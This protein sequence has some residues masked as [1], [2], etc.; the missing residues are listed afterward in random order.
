MSSEAREQGRGAF[1]PGFWAPD[2][3]GDGPERVVRPKY[4]ES[5]SLVGRQPRRPREGP[6]PCFATVAGRISSL[7]D[8]VVHSSSSWYY[9]PTVGGLDQVDRLG[10][11]HRFFLLIVSLILDTLTAIVPGLAS[12]T[13]AGRPASR[14]G[15]KRLGDA[16][17][18][19]VTLQVAPM[20][21]SRRGPQG[22]SS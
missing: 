15:S 7:G 13:P 10:G 20:G 3:L 6:C 5:R 12:S 17:G 2:F 19:G 11:R 1:S 8:A 4:C 18:R 14:R 21:G 22:T 9:K 16:E